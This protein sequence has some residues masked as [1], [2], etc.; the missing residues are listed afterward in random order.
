MSALLV[1]M[2]EMFSSRATASPSEVLRHATGAVQPGET[3][4]K[5]D[6]AEADAT[7]PMQRTLHKVKTCTISHMHPVRDT[8]KD[9]GV[10]QSHGMRN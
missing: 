5:D 1:S 3:G 4:H 9:S 2:A 10:G 8:R 6:G 7:S